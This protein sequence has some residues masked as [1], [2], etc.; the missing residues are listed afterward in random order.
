M[1]TSVLATLLAD[2]A[3][4]CI[5][6]LLLAASVGKL[7]SYGDFRGNL[8]TSFGVPPGAASLAAPALVM[9]E[10]SLAGW[11]L[12]GG[13]HIPMLLSLLLLTTLTAVL[14]WRYFTHSVVRCSCFGE[15]ARPVSR[16]DL[17]R[18]VLA[19]GINGAYFAL[20]QETTLPVA[21]TALAAG[22]AAIVCVATISLHD[23]ATLAKAD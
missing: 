6:L 4:Y 7:R 11:L 12:A 8:A 1:L 5:A 3:R 16:Y 18:N 19:V 13:T 14:A 17:L 10:L 20:A 22:L 9:A 23:I 2:T 15:A 21:T